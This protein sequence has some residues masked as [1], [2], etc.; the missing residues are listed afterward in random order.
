L[1]K[2]RNTDDDQDNPL[3][4]ASVEKAFKVLTAFSPAQ[5]RMTLTQ[6]V[7]QTGM[8]KSSTQRF[9]H[10]LTALGYLSKDPETK[11]FELAL[12]VLELGYHYVASSA[13]IQLAMPYL[14]HLSQVTEETV[15]MTFLDGTDVVFVARLMGRNV[16]SLDTVVGSRLPAYC[17]ASGVAMLSKM[18]RKEALAV[19]DKSD[20]R[21]ITPATV[22]KKD[23]LVKK[24]DLSAKRGYATTFEEYFHGDLSIAAP[25]LN[26]SGMPVAGVS[27]SVS[28]ARY[29]PE[30][31]E[32]KFATQVVAC[33]LSIRPR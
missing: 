19:L 33:A 12:K 9:T 20:R 2:V 6:L 1:A 23:D 5:S 11:Q 26:H 7:A 30:E 24:L 13:L 15:N 8:D 21:A 32:A 10:T 4:V 25:I 29:S 27:V 16:L 17:S 3:H 18:P 22:Y 31:V 28:R 14:L